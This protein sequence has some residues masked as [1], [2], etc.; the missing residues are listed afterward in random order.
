MSIQ[1]LSH[2]V[3]TLTEVRQAEKMN[4]TTY[5]THNRHHKDAKNCDKT[6]DCSCGCM[7]DEDDAFG[8]VNR[9]HQDQRDL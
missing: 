7:E 9:T 1:D 3:S 5:N 6:V 8:N 4:N 2:D